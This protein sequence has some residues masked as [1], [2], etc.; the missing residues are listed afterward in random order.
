[1]PDTQY[2][3]TYRPTRVTLD[4]PA[5]AAVGATVNVGCTFPE[6]YGVKTTD[7]IT[8]TCNRVPVPFSWDAMNQ[9][10]TFTMPD[11]TA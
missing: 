4:G 11:P 9:R 3:I 1:M 5:T 8:V 10:V 2:P 6:G 7:S